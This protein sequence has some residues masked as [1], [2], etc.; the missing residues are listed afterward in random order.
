MFEYISKCIQT[1]LQKKRIEKFPNIFNI[2]FLIA[3]FTAGK[4]LLKDEKGNFRVSNG[5]AGNVYI[6]DNDKRH[7]IVGHK[8]V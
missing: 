5:P 3:S 1:E 7:V 8:L 2:I 4:E 6:D